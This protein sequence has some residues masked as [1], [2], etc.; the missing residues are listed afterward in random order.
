[1]YRFLLLFVFIFCSR[2]LAAPEPHIRWRTLQTEHFEII[3]DADHPLLA[4]E[5]ALQAER[6]YSLLVPVFQTAPSKTV[7]WIYDRSDSPNGLATPF[8]RPMITLFPVLPTALDSIGHYDNWSQKLLIHEYTHILNMEP[9]RGF[10][11]PVRTLLGAIVRPNALLPTWYLEGLAV[12]ME[13]RFTS[14]GRLRSPLFAAMMRAMVLDNTWNQS[15]ASMN[16]IMIPSWPYGMRPY[17]WGSLLLHEIGKRKGVEAFRT[18]NDQYAGRVPF[19]INGPIHD[20]L[21]VS[22]EGFAQ[23][24]RETYKKLADVQIEKIKSASPP[25]SE[26]L[27]N[28]LPGAHSPTISPNQLRLAYVLFN[29][30]RDSEIWMVERP[31]TKVPFDFHQQKKLHT[32]T[33]TKKISWWPNS[34]SL[35]FDAIDT[36]D[37]YYEYSDLHRLFLS[38]K[39][40]DPVTQGL[41]AQEPAVDSGGHRIVYVKTKAATSQLAVLTGLPEEK[42]ENIVYSPPQLH[43]I[44][45]PSFFSEDEILFSERSPQG[46]EVLKIFNL[47]TKDVRIALGDYS[48]AQ[49]AVPYKNGIL[50]T[51]AKSGIAN[52]YWASRD[53]KTIKALTNSY[54]EANTATIDS[55]TSTLYFSELTGRGVAL[56]RKV[57]SHTTPTP[58][59]SLTESDW[60]K[61]EEPTKAIISSQEEEYSPWSYM[62]PT[63]WVPLVGFFGNSYAVSAMTGAID[64]LRIQSYALNVNYDSLTKKTGGG[65]VFSRAIHHGN[66]SL[67][68]QVVNQYFYS[69]DLITTSSYLEAQYDMPLNRHNKDWRTGF[70]VSRFS[71][72]LP[73]TSDDYL[74]AGPAVQLS[75]LNATQ[76]PTQISPRKGQE[77]LLDYQYFLPSWGNTEFYNL[78]AN[79]AIYISPWLPDRHAMM[80]RTRSIFSP[81][82][83]SILLGTPAGGDYTLSYLSESPYLV[84]GYPVGEF[85][86]WSLITNTFE[87]R[88]PLTDSPGDLGTF[89]VLFRR[90]HAGVFVDSATLEGAY[91]AKD[92]RGTRTS[93]L[94]SFFWS[95]GME[96]R[97]DITLGFHIPAMLKLGLY[98]GLNT[99]A[100]GGFSTAITLSLPK[101]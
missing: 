32:S 98:Y 21:G 94:G 23:S 31:N 58:T 13:T 90:W 52:L 81:R 28:T 10:L 33:G 73:T 17:F 61:Y 53:F 100:Y 49:F 96:F 41:R 46:K 60:P 76:K 67:L 84:R 39:K 51:S 38:D 11:G 2:G 9:A 88:F 54:T 92:I 50:F 24:V 56:K 48:P 26:Q 5:V 19:F 35:V 36:E 4:Q 72:D 37:L 75:Y 1:M 14:Q 12:E 65:A 101:L 25:T 63:Y 77:A 83:R 99:N 34:E 18:L 47:A 64:P 16:E 45:R 20:L 78:R 30:D 71:T 3:F 91:Y 69:Y 82:N 95:T 86:G 74:Y 27:P 42:K 43:R 79:G 40:A 8:P 68:G 89:P 57:L 22:Y 93:Y 70:R 15:L 66:V 97:S 62:L 80:L 55:N 85:V 6:T 87:Y 7:I 29:D 44:S 59:A